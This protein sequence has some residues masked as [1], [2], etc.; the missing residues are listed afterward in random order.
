MSR[1]LMLTGLILALVQTPAVAE[2]VATSSMSLKPYSVTYSVTRGRMRIGEMRAE[3]SRGEDD[4]WY[5][6]TSAR[7]VGVAALLS[8]LETEEQSVFRVTD[9]LVT[10]RH[11]YTMSGDRRNRNFDIHF[12]WQSMT[13]HGDIR[14]EAVEHALPAGAVDRHAMTLAVMVD[15][16]SERPFPRQHVMIDRARVR[17]LATRLDGNESLATRAGQFDTQRIVQQ[18]LDDPTRRYI[19]WLAAVNDAW[20]PI[21]IQSVDDDGADFT[22]ELLQLGN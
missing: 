12:D 13:L 17:E 9:S 7:P 4:I 1:S 3:L 11:T 21:R 20:L 6:R 10:L 18:R 22:L 16:I 19:M 14:G 2:P 15:I 5:Y 8:G